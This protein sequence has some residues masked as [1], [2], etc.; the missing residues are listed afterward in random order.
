MTNLSSHIYLIVNLSF[1]S[2]VSAWE[3]YGQAIGE[4]ERLEEEG[5]Y[6]Y[7]IIKVP[8]NVRNGAIAEA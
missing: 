5:E 4:K 3:D 2:P 6:L 8:L 7:D 1:S